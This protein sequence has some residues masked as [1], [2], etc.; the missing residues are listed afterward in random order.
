LPLRTLYPTGS[1]PG[2]M[3]TK[4]IKRRAFFQGIQARRPEPR[5]YSGP[6]DF[7]DPIRNLRTD[8]DIENARAEVDRLR[9]L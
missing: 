3:G 8:L 7:S 4:D 2:R 1:V 6:W 5:D 9:K